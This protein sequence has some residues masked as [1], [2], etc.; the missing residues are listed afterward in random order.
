MPYTALG[1]TLPGAVKHGGFIPWDDAVASPDA[2][3]KLLIAAKKHTKY[4]FFFSRVNYIDGSVALMNV[5]V[6]KNGETTDKLTVENGEKVFPIKAAIFV[7]LLI[8]AS[9]IKE[10]GYPI[11]DFHLV[12]RHRIRY[13]NYEKTH[14]TVR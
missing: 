11:K 12:G 7:S 8:K 13:E 5:C 2:V 4:A 1:G 6:S 9:L 3:E 10:F 14:R